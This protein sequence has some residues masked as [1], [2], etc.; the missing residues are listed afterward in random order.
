MTD[1]F[2]SVAGMTIINKNN[3]YPPPPK[4][5]TK[6]NKNKNTHTK[7][8]RKNKKTSAGCILNVFSVLGYFGNASVFTLC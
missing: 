6:Q 1:Y 2:F 3:N 4:T 5:T 7:P 8:P